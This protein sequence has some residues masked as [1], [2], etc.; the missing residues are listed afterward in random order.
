MKPGRGTRFRMRRVVEVD[1]GEHFAAD[2]FVAGPKDEVCTPLHGL[3][4]VGDG[5]QIS[6]EAFGIHG[7]KVLGSRGEVQGGS[8]VNAV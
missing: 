2:G 5:Q 3:D 6:A 4:D 7:G 1:E 8:R